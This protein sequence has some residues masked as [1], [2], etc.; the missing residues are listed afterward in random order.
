[1]NPVWENA[2]SFIKTACWSI[3]GF[4]YSS[5]PNRNTRMGKRG[6]GMFIHKHEDT[7]L[8]LLYTL[9]FIE[10]CWR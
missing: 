5:N 6:R 8:H 7:S 2:G 4:D 3:G 9:T 10:H 1:M